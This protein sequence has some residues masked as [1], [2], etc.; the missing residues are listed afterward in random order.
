MSKMIA[1][2]V[3]HA[4]GKFERI[5]RDI[6]APGPRELLIRVHACGVCHSDVLTVEGLM[7]GITYPRVPGHEV[8]GTIE[9]VGA[10]VAGWRVGDRAGVGW[11]GGSCG[12]A[13]VTPLPARTSER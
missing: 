9:G 6:P 1:M 13:A 7:P 8:I 2:A 12:S 3:P 4:G 10:D 11:F 5:E